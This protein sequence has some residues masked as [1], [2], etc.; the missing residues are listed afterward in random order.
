MTAPATAASPASTGDALHTLYGETM[1]T[2]WRVVLRAGARVALEPLHARVQAVLDGVVACMSDWE[3]DS[4]VSRFNVA[5]AG[6]WQVLP[7]DLRRVVGA[8]ID[9]ARDSGG[10]FDPTV[11]PLV[12]LW[13]FG[14]RAVASVGAP[15]A[16]S[17]A[18]A[19]ARC[20]WE[21]L[22]LRHEDDGVALLQP[23]GLVL[24]LSAIAKGHAADAV[25]AALR[26]AGITAA[27]VDVGGE[28]VAFGARPDGSAWRVLVE[29]DAVDADGRDGA[30][31]CVLRLETRAVATSGGRWHAWDAGDGAPTHTIDPRSGRPV[32]AS[33][34]VT[35]VA[36]DAMHADAW[37]TALA[38][39]GG[40][41]LAFATAHGLA[42][43][44]VDRDGDGARRVRSTAGFDACV[45]GDAR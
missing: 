38:V 40:D 19:R 6:T 8:A 34:A 33:V 18:T 35:V 17:L 28:L 36:A 2:T 3:P 4:D 15:D 7:D 32:G 22:Q 23:G 43:R 44:I 42:A 27:L 9:V 29:S 39:M 24:D 5:A 13:G 45:D 1:G 31:P 10:A 14:A 21:R 16:A 25:A 20:G 30:P 11:S 26:D 37:A 12:A 41:A